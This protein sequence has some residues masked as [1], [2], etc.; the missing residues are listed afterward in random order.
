MKTIIKRLKR[1]F[2]QLKKSFKKDKYKFYLG[3]LIVKP[4]GNSVIKNGQIL[5]TTNGDIGYVTNLYTDTFN[6]V[7]RS[8]V[9]L[10]LRL[11]NKVKKHIHKDNL[12]K[13]FIYIP[14]MNKTFELS[15]SCYRYILISDKLKV[16]KIRITIRGYAMLSDKTK[17]EREY[18]SILRKP[19]FGSN[20]LNQLLS[21]NY[22]IKKL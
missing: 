19:L 13:L 2:K 21:S 1:F 8:S 11:L 9:W 20:M 15:P 7:P 10:D 3:V 6:I 12:Y 16:F 14:F 18:I 5:M 22:K 17:K 4:V